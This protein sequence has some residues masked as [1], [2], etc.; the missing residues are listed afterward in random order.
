MLDIVLS[1]GTTG[2]SWTLCV[3]EGDRHGVSERGI[4]YLDLW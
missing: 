2:T 3:N 4:G 1:A